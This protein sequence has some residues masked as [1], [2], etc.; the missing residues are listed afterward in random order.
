MCQ[1]QGDVYEGSGEN[2]YRINQQQEEQKPASLTNFERNLSGLSNLAAP[3]PAAQVMRAHTHEHTHI[4]TDTLTHTHT[5]TGTHR[6]YSAVF[7]LL[8]IGV[9][10]KAG[11]MLFEADLKQSPMKHKDA[12]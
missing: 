6:L 7:T 4:H 1:E 8:H 3:G 11:L 5:H 12:I 10:F 9:K 2:I